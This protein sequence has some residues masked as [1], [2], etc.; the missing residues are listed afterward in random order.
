MEEVKNEVQTEEIE[1][2]IQ[3]VPA[4]LFNVK[5]TH[6]SLRRRSTPEIAKNVVGII[7]DG[8]IYP[9]YDQNGDWGKLEDGTWIMLKYTE[10]ISE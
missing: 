1:W 3:D 5:V 4:I 9:I 2:Q 7:S 8:G 6:P 10:K